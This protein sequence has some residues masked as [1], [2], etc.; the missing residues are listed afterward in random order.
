ME[1]TTI[2]YPF[3]RTQT[4]SDTAAGMTFPDPYHWLESG[5]EEV[6]EWQEKQNNLADSYIEQWPYL[7]SLKDRVNRYSLGSPLLPICA[8]EHW[9]RIDVDKYTGATA[10]IMS[11]SPCSEGRIVFTLSNAEGEFLVWLS[12]SPNGKV[13]AVGICHDGSENNRIRL[14]D[15][16]TGEDIPHAP[17][18][19]LM[20][21]LTGGASWLPDSSGFYFLALIG[22]AS[23]F[24]QKIFFHSLLE[25]RQ[26]PIDIP[27]PDPSS[28]DY[29]AVTISSDG[30]YRIAHQGLTVL[31]PVAVQDLKK[32]DSTWVPFMT[33]VDGSV[34]GQVLNDDFIAVTDV[35]APRGRIIRVPLHT[36]CPND[37][38][39]WIEL[40]PESDAV[41]RSL[42]IVGNFIYITESIDTFSRIR[43]IDLSG[44]PIGEVPLPGK[45]AVNE[46]AFPIMRL[47]RQKSAEKFLFGFSTLT[48]SWGVYSHKPG[49][50][51]IDTLCEPE[52]CIHGAVVEQCWV[53]S[54]DGTKVPY[55][56]VR[57][58]T[59]D[60]Q[61][62]QPTLMFGYGGFNVAVPPKFVGAIG[63]FIESGGVYVLTHLRGG[64]EFGKY[65]WQSGSMQNTQNTYDDLYAIAEDM[66][67]KKQT[68]ANRLALI[69]R[70]KGGLLA[71]VALTQRPELWKVVVPQVPVLDLIGTL[72][73]PYGR[74]CCEIEYGDPQNPIE[75]ACVADYS[76]YHH[77]KEG[78]EYPS[79][80]LDAGATDPRC[81]PWHARKLAARLQTVSKGETPIL[82]RVWENT[83]HGPATNHN[84]QIAQTT[85]WLAFVMCQ[86]GM[87]PP[88]YNNKVSC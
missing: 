37:S 20:D 16:A 70:S 72:R 17:T 58:E 80:F 2:T 30:R 11:Q 83:G 22:N 56:T 88:S 25:E 50:T 52:I 15:V 26:I 33:D 46:A 69:G 76:P 60:A 63:T 86:L 64:N 82:L 45:G 42:T 5:S 12:P 81:P 35:D 32:M 85:A 27:L 51:K 68:S 31:R 66:I 65:W 48:E 41:L 62:P 54:Y 38:S 19:W 43:I 87:C 84:A 47:A 7:D 8:G 3:A 59:T 34:L 4:Y 67:E 6:Q 78:T 55:H 77:I 40:V 24:R 61:I 18:H 14:V 10:V 39:K 75:L 21:G 23:E 29:V 13:L 71:G 79:V 1:N 28:R 74:Y 49:D 53:H 73:H 36:E 57:L 44:N 9:F